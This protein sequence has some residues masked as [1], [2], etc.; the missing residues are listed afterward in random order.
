MNFSRRHSH[1]PAA[2]MFPPAAA[3]ISGFGGRCGRGRAGCDSAEL[4]REIARKAAAPLPPSTS[5][6]AYVGGRGQEHIGFGEVC[7]GGPK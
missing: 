6:P 2:S 3:D 4:S 7:L 5:E 1:V